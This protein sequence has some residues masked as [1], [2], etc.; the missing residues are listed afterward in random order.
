M[1]LDLNTLATSRPVNH[2]PLDLCNAI[3]AWFRGS[4]VGII[5]SA[6]NAEKGNCLAANGGGRSTNLMPS[7]H[8]SRVLRKRATR[9]ETVYNCAIA[10]ACDRWLRARGLT[11]QKENFNKSNTTEEP[12]TDGLP[13]P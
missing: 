7:A 4:D 8:K 9:N 13:L 2:G 11:A 3:N 1:S 6:L 5:S 12:K 10:L